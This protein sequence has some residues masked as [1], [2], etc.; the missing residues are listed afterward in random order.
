MSKKQLK[1]EYV[2]RNMGEDLAP[3][4]YTFHLIDPKLKTKEWALEY[5]KSIYPQMTT[6]FNSGMYGGAYDYA[7]IRAYGQGKQPDSIYK[8]MFNPQGYAQ[9]RAGATGA[10]NNSSNDFTGLRWNI[11]SPAQKYKNIVLAE[12]EK[13]PV[14]VQCMA[15]DVLAG[16]KRGKDMQLLKAQK[17]ADQF[18]SQVSAKLQLP[19]PMKSNFGKDVL[20]SSNNMS[21]FKDIEFNFD[22]DVELQMYMDVYYKQA[23][24]IANEMCI[25]TI[26]KQ[27]KFDEILKEVR[28]D[29]LD[30][31]VA[32]LHPYMDNNTC[33]PKI[34]WLRLDQVLVG[35]GRRRDF[36][37]SD[38]W[39][40]PELLT[41]NQIIGKFGKQLTPNK[42]KEIFKFG[43]ET[44]GYYDNGS[45]N[46]S[47]SNSPSGNGFNWEKIGRMDFDRVSVKVSYI[48]FKSQNAETREYV[49]VKYGET[50]IK[51]QEYGYTTDNKNGKVV[52]HWGQVVYKGYYVVGMD[53]IFDFGLLPNMVRREGREQQVMLDLIMYKFADKSFTENMITHLDGIEL[54]YL[55]LQLEILMAIPSGYVIDWDALADI[56]T[57]QSFKDD[58]LAYVQ[59]FTQTGKYIKRSLNEDGDL[60][61]N[62]H[63]PAI[64]RLENGIANAINGYIEAIKFHTQQLEADIGFNPVA[65]GNAPQPRASATGEKISAQA[66]D[67]ANYFLVSGMMTMFERTAQYVSSLVQDMIT[68]KG[69]GYDSLK[70]MVGAMNVS[71]ME[72]M[73]DIPLHQFG[74][75]VQEK[76]S[77]ADMQQFKQFVMDAYA[78]NELDLSDVILVYF[79]ENYKQAIA[80]F[81]L[82]RSKQ[83]EKNQQMQAQ[84]AQMQ[85]KTAAEMN[86]LKMQIAQLESDAKKQSAD[87]TG[88]WAY[89]TEQLKEGAKPNLH[90]VDSDLKIQQ[91]QAKGNIEL[92]KE[93]MKA[94]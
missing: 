44:Y 72:S 5:I 93:A 10:G 84:G 67:N 30:F 51:T 90:M 83:I 31:G 70:A 29:A 60:L 33:M 19:K 86:Q 54:C 26:F 3:F 25:N 38:S 8:S 46:Q 74:I 12:L 37:D 42:I 40:Y 36:D 68:Y 78:K 14:E 24:E 82:K 89:M 92:Q 94:A 88:K 35:T 77:D 76:M 57:G 20:G 50:K 23:V 7:T 13:M 45:Y 53:E 43:V 34:E 15:T 4:D 6:L 80:L 48:A 49:K 47:W 87:I 65:A 11:T 21:Q 22:S 85:Q 52:N 79:L 28:N 1:V 39:A 64:Q 63:L 55:K 66:V 69:A 62:A 71:I 61:P 91:I 2:E 81:N 16:K 9:S 73:D 75:Y 59:M 32:A 56:S 17:P 18:L 58:P 41:V 27:N